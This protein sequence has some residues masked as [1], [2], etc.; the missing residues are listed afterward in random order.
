MQ[1][2]MALDGR[3]P[4]VDVPMRAVALCE[5]E[6]DAIKAS[7]DLRFPGKS[8]GWVAKRIGMSRTFFN[9]IKNG[10]KTMPADRVAT[11]C[12]ECGVNLLRQYRDL[13]RQMREHEHGQSAVSRIAHITREIVRNIR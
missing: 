10:A 1:A 3:M 5:S 13:Q 6:A 4:P 2:E 9:E 7:L 11:F 12:Q 8:D